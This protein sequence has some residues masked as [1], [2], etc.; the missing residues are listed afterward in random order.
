M[1]AKK[2]YDYSDKIITFLIKQFI[3]I[4][5]RLRTVLYFDELNILDNVNQVY[6]ELDELSQTWLT[7]IAIK[8]YKDA[9]GED[10]SFI[11]LQW[12]TENILGEYDKVTKYVYTNE[13]DRKRS[14]LAESLIASDNK[15]TEID[16]A[17]KLWSAMISQYAITAVDTA[18][19]AAYKSLGVRE[20]VW[21]S[22]KDGRRCKVCMERDGKVYSIDEVPPKP[23]IGCRCYLVPKG[24]KNN[25]K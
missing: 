3:E 11:N 23:H 13:V 5:G 1:R 19:L 18:T 17:L 8:A 7:N 4:F 21:K 20:V 16:K 10:N 9:G 2:M 14:R 24:R 12:L 22:I 6:W 25:G 15:S